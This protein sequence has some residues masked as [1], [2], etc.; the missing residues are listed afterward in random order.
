MFILEPLFSP[1]GIAAS[2]G[3]VEY[4]KE[5]IELGH[6]EWDFALYGACYG[7][8]PNIV[9]IIIQKAKQDSYPLSWNFGLEAACKNDQFRLIELMIEKGAENFNNSLFYSKK[10]PKTFKRLFRIV[11]R[12]KMKGYECTY[13][14]RHF[15]HYGLYIDTKREIMQEIF[16]ATMIRNILLG[17]GEEWD[18]LR[19]FFI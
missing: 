14:P 5:I 1:I 12:Y 10:N 16:S 8:H 9:E 4:F 18:V 19:R 7:G 15:L 17:Y 3:N 2:S 11:A 13:F 6:D